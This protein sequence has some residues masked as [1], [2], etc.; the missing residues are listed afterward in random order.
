[1]NKKRNNERKK[2]ETIKCQ[3]KSEMQVTN[4]Q[5]KNED[6]IK[7]NN[8]S[9]ENKNRSY[10][11]SEKN[12]YLEAQQEKEIIEINNR[13]SLTVDEIIRLQKNK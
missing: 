11:Q 10:H 4:V 9:Q 6:Y 12:E 3:N 8:A 1:M 7:Y 13:N 5:S 2:N